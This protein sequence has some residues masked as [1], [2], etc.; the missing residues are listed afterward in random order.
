MRKYILKYFTIKLFLYKVF[1]HNN[2]TN[3]KKITQ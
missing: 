2:K 1:I 3:K